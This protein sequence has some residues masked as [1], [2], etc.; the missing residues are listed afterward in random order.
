MFS[1][2]FGPFLIKTKMSSF[3]LKQDVSQSVTGLIYDTKYFRIGKR[4]WCI[5]FAAWKPR[6][7][8]GISEVQLNIVIHSE[9]SAK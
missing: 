8:N 7:Y 9:I 4:K 1:N 2:A 5:S 6:Y 3:Y